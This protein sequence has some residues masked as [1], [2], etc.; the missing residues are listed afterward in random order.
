MYQ[1]R[2]KGVPG[3]TQMGRIGHPPNISFAGELAES[4]W[5]N[6]GRK[7][8]LAEKSGPPDDSATHDSANSDFFRAA[9]LGE[10]R[11]KNKKQTSERCGRVRMGL[12][13]FG[14]HIGGEDNGKDGSQAPPH[15]PLQGV[16][17]SHWLVPLIFLRFQG[18]T[19]PSQGCHRSLQLPFPRRTLD[20]RPLEVNRLT[21]RMNIGDFEQSQG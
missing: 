6:H 7:K 16:T 10:F 15:P 8:K 17:L 20:S 9:P 14:F 13:G 11:P 3:R 2:T 5:Q 4:C 1:S 21:T 18:V 19:S 12:V